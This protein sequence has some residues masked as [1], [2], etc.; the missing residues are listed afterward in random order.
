MLYLVA[1]PIGNSGD[2]SLR[3]ISV[4]EKAD[5]LLCEDTRKTGSLLSKLKIK[6]K[7][8]LFSF[9]DE[10]EDK[11]VTKVVSWLKEGREVALLSDAGSPLVSDPGW[12]LLTRCQRENIKYT[13]LPGA[14]AV[15]NALILS[16]M[17]PTPFCFL[18]FLSKKKSKRLKVLKGVSDLDMTKIIYESPFRLSKL[19]LDI[20]KVWGGDKKVTICREMTKKHE[21]VV[22]SHISALIEKY[23]NHRIKGEV[24]VVVE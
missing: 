6:N 7:P 17:S 12:R 3:A 9:Y 22:K 8:I 4:L 10:V 15:I 18:G 20:E 24:V 21:E 14:S 16:G 11:R 19:L 23:K 5:I 2:I 1:V 13:S